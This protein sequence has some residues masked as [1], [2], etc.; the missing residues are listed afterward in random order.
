MHLN[1]PICMLC[2]RRLLQSTSS[3]FQVQAL[4]YGALLNATQPTQPQP[5]TAGTSISSPG[6]LFVFLPPLGTNNT[7]CSWATPCDNIQQAI[8]EAPYDGATIW[9]G[10]GKSSYYPYSQS[11][12]AT[13]LSPSGRGV[14][15]PTWARETWM[16]ASTA[17]RCT[18]PRW[19]ARPTRSST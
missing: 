15:A 17:A 2:R 1:M 16:S 19:R 12:P 14:Q 3:Y 18:W 8:V 7:A 10:P 6:N 11:M 4:A 9:M 13:S 5:T